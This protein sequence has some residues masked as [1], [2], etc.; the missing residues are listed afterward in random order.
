MSSCSVIGRQAPRPEAPHP[1]PA[2]DV[3]RRAPAPRPAGGGR[4]WPGIGAV[5]P[6]HREG[7]R[8]RDRQRPRL[9]RQ[10]GEPPAGQSRRKIVTDTGC[11]DQY[12]QAPL[13]E[14]AACPALN[15]VTLSGRKAPPE[16]PLFFLGRRTTGTRVT[17]APARNAARV[18]LPRPAP[19]RTNGGAAWRARGHW[20][21]RSTRT[22][23]GR[24]GRPGNNSAG[25]ADSRTSNLGPVAVSVFFLNTDGL[26][27]Q[28][29]TFEAGG[30][31]RLTT[32]S[33]D[34]RCGTAATSC[35]SPFRCRKFD[36]CQRLNAKRHGGLESGCGAA[37]G[38]RSTITNRSR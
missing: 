7:R 3:A 10:V 17:P 22:R 37:F 30:E 14:G 20:D 33:R 5:C 24:A 21:T 36:I 28:H 2:S 6:N 34:A 13:F 16:C 32:R 11:S 8:C 31:G 23:H 27:A 25:T 12:R 15:R 1:P 18:T 19:R 38:D 26:A 9:W 4:P 29:R 35:R